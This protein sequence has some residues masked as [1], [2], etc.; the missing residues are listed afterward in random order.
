MR[1]PS[2]LRDYHDATIEG[3]RVLQ[4]AFED[5]ESAEDL[6]EEAL[7]RL[8]SL[9]L[10]EYPE[11]TEELESIAAELPECEGVLDDEA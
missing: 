2:D 10:D 9:G 1:P 8:G 5:P 7:E 4:S 3:L 6:D 11:I